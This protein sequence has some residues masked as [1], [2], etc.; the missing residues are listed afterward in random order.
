M[1]GCS[2][3]LNVTTSEVFSVSGVLHSLSSLT[4][5]TSLHTELWAPVETEGV[6]CDIV[7]TKNKKCEVLT[8]QTRQLP[9]NVL[10]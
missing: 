6:K 5:N 3:C 10:L 2:S 9:L 8:E 4:E 7:Q 1:L